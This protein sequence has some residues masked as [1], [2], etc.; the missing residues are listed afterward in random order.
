MILDKFF[1][2]YKGW[3]GGGGEEGGRGEGV[4]LIL[5]LPPQKKQPSKSPALLGLISVVAFT[6][7]LKTK[8]TKLRCEVI[9]ASK[10]YFFISD[11]FSEKQNEVSDKIV[12]ANIL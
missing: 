12:V 7:F 9:L 6:Y 10:A 11:S 4:K 8:R 2:K 1:L 3:R 5:P